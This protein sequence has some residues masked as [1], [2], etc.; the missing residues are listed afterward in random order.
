M[1]CNSAR[2][3]EWQSANNGDFTRILE[4]DLDGSGSGQTV[5]MNTVEIICEVCLESGRTFT[6]LTATTRLRE[7]LG[8][9][10]LELAILTVKLEAEFGVDVFMDGVVNTVG[11]IED[12]IARGK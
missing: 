11:E 10:S 2:P 1:S 4:T 9:D 5:R 6:E 12:R 8:T 3:V 7:D